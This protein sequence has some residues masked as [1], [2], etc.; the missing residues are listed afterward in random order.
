MRV[1]HVSDSHIQMNRPVSVRHGYDS[2]GVGRKRRRQLQCDSL[3]TDFFAARS[4]S[5]VLDRQLN[6]EINWKS[7]S[8]VLELLHG[9]LSRYVVTAVLQPAIPE[10]TPRTG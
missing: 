8:T 4:Q 10:S 9:R 1:S 7:R 2:T 6:G 3:L 5:S